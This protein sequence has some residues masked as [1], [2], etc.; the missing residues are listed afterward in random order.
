MGGHTTTAGPDDEWLIISTG[1]D[2]LTE[3]DVVLATD[4]YVDL[5]Y[6]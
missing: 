5:P 4:T 2:W 3:D 1:S 6:R